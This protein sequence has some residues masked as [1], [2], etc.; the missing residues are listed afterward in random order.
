MDVVSKT[1]GNKL[2]NRYKQTNI[3]RTLAKE[4]NKI[5]RKRELKVVEVVGI[6]YR[7]CHALES[8]SYCFLLVQKGF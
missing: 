1:R 6:I 4:M 8:V 2:K 7:A 5:G 3:M